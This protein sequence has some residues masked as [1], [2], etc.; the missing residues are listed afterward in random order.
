MKMRA[1]AAPRIAK[2]SNNLTSDNLIAG[3][4][5]NLLK[6]S[7]TAFIAKAMVDNHYV[8]IAKE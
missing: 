2:P 6:M 3:F 4:Y 7:I 5:F 1:G 8:A